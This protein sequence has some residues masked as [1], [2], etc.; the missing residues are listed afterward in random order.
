MFGFLEIITGAKAVVPLVP[1]VIKIVEKLNEQKQDP[2][3]ARILQQVRLDTLEGAQRLRDELVALLQDK[4]MDSQL[5]VP[6]KKVGDDLS[7]LRDPIKKRRVQK[8]RDRINGIHRDLTSSTD[9]LAGILACMQRT[10]GLGD[11]YVAAEAA[12]AELDGLLSSQPPVR[13]V[14][15]TYVTFLDRYLE[16]LQS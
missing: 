1:G 16:R 12:R 11:A 4:T 9:D 6:L 7:W 15:E 14:L 5:N 2:N 3:L 8:Y 10:E 13:K